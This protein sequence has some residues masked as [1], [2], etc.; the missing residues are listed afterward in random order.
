MISENFGNHFEHS[1]TLEYFLTMKNFVNFIQDFFFPFQK[2]F[3][4]FQTQ[5]IKM[6]FSIV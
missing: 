3:S 5:S 6:Y 2:T 4:N 1:R